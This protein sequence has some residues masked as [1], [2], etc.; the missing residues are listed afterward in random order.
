MFIE[1][2]S[3]TRNDYLQH[4]ITLLFHDKAKTSSDNPSIERIDAGIMHPP[5]H[6]HTH[7]RTPSQHINIFNLTFFFMMIIKLHLHHAS[8][9]YNHSSLCFYVLVL[10]MPMRVCCKELNLF[11]LNCFKLSCTFSDVKMEKRNKT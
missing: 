8:L 2:L 11:Y 5:P 3:N 7:A 4:F 6:T 10:N 9:H 1:L